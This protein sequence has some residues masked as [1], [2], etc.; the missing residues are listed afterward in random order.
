M[1]LGGFLAV[2]LPAFRAGAQDA[3]LWRTNQNGVSVDIK[4][5]D[6]P[7]LLQKISAATGWRVYIEPGTT[8]NVTARFKDVSMEEALNRLLARVNYTRDVSN[9]IP[10]LLVYRTVAGAA[11]QAV[12]IP[13]PDAPRDYRIPN[14]LIIRLKRNSRESIDDIA[15]AL[16]AKVLERDESLRLYRLQ[17]A[18][19]AAANAAAGQLGGDTSVARVDSNYVVDP[20]TL[21]QSD[22]LAA[23]AG[24]AS[25][26][27]PT[28]PANGKVLGLID[29]AVQMQAPM[30]PYSLTPLSVVGQPNPS[31]DLITHG[32][33]MFETMLQAM[34]DAPGKILPV[35]VYPD[36]DSTT[37]YELAEGIIAAVNA[38][39]NP[40][41]ISSGGTGDSSMLRDLI[42]EGTQKGILFV[43]AS[44]NTPGTAPTYPAA[45][46]G[47]LAVTASGP[48]G[49]LAPYA[50]DGSFVQAM[51]PGT[52]I[53]FLNGQAWQVQGT[54]PATAFA[55]ASIVEM[56]NSQHLTLSQAVTQ[57]VQSHP[58]PR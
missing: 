29:T 13:K 53:V 5:W 39:A 6:L 38:G 42:A 1:I 10:R 27:N 22:P 18:D 40:I 20:P 15:R 36:G 28:T 46:P 30:Q 8:A 35:D 25:L 12:E 57:F 23:P 51:A 21:A 48:N 2:L 32:T 11:T 55:S 45:Y 37:T 31:D 50:D 33:S 17:F 41:S 24:P 54:S 19:E 26:L 7:K 14:E 49:Q 4:D 47:V 43:A 16:G 58:P 44:G 9:G 34:A 52:S 56:M 3:P